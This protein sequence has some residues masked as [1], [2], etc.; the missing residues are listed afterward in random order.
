MELHIL[1]DIARSLHSTAYFT[2]MVDECTHMSNNE[3]LVICFCWVDDE[4]QVH[5]FE[6]YKNLQNLLI[7]AAN[8]KWFEDELKATTSFYGTHL[9]SSTLQVQ[10][11]TVQSR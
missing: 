7:Q 2:V 1:W 10:L 8:K 6:T 9:E 11:E 5:G 4:L 3:H